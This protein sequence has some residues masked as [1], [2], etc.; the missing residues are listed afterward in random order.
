VTR[1][2]AGNLKHFPRTRLVQRKEFN[3][4]NQNGILK[5]CGL[6][7]VIKRPDS[8]LVEIVTIL[9][10]V[11]KIYGILHDSTGSQHFLLFARENF[12]ISCVDFFLECP[13]PRL[14]AKG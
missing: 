12:G 6:S 9:V 7:V 10:I 8:T 13:V 14:V 4:Q 2:T 11:R 3:F 5:T 1:K